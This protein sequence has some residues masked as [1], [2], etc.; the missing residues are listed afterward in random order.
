MKLSFWKAR[1]RRRKEAP[2]YR[3]E[4]SAGDVFLISFPR[5]GNTWL[6]HMLML[7][8]P[9]IDGTGPRDMHRIIPNLDQ[10]PD[11]TQT[12]APRVIK[13][14][15][16]FDARFPRVIYLLRDGR[17]AT[18]SYY[19]FCRK[20]FGYTGSFRDFLVQAPYPPSRWHEHVVSWLSRPT[21]ALLVIRYEDMLA[22]PER[23]LRRAL[24][25]L[26]WRASDERIDQAVSE[27]SLGRMREKEREGYFL[28]HV[29]L[30]KKEDWRDRYSSEEFEI[31]MR[32]A[33]DTLR[34][35]GYE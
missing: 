3:P 35:F 19:V 10:K 15:C 8:H 13:S 6:R 17:D 25:F 2:E 12:P 24:E 18:Y 27:S 34:R 1:K 33:S 22:D 9:G 11:L 20:E 4:I 30:G 14:H 32:D 31:F 16:L 29:R 7:L 26:D 28:A 23:E 21:E 5:S